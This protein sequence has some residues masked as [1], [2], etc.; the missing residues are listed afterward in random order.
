MGA[1]MH[2]RTNR[3]S[4]LNLS[5]L[6]QRTLHFLATLN[7][8]EFYTTPTMC[9]VTHF[10]QCVTRVEL[11]MPHNLDYKCSGLEVRRTS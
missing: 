11:R 5:F 9:F 1:Q 8:T 2:I 7:H 4:T 10:L 3:D 6:N